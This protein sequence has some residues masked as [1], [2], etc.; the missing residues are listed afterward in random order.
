MNK[1]HL[2]EFSSQK[3]IRQVISAKSNLYDFL[4]DIYQDRL[5]TLF[6]EHGQSKGFISIFL[7]AQQLFSILN[8]HLNNND[9]I[10]IISSISGG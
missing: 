4:L 9:E 8:V 7:N 5:S 3:N 10:Q 1:Y 6:D 2:I